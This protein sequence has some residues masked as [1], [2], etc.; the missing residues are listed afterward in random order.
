VVVGFQS[1]FVITKCS[2]Y[3]FDVRDR[4]AICNDGF[5]HCSSDCD[6]TGTNSYEHDVVAWIQTIR[7]VKL[8]RV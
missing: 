8:L 6:T 3:L 4:V 1:E 5:Q 2:N 7:I